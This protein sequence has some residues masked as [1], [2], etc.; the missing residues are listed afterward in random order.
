MGAWRGRM[1]RDGPGTTDTW[2]A[3]RY[4]AP[5]RPRFDPSVVE[6]TVFDVLASRRRRLILEHLLSVEGVVSAGD[7]AEHIAAIETGT[8]VDQL[9]SYD[10]KR[11]YVSLYQ[12]HLPKLAAANVI[13]YDVDRKT[14][15]VGD[16]IEAL[17]P[18]LTGAPTRWGPRHRGLG[19]VGLGLVVLLGSLQ[20]GPFVVAPPAGW[21]GLGI[22]G[23]VGLA[24]M[25][26]YRR[27]AWRSD[28]GSTTLEQV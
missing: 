3:V 24:A 6:E 21:I 7:L 8:S 1:K 28:R 20:A 4:P 19:S 25:D 15:Q 10:R 14:V 22:V 26:V 23:L 11:V 16:S 5:G 9:S 13:D 18:Y 12:N 2:T 17:E 27:N